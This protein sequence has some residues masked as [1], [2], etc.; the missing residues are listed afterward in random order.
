MPS[1]RQARQTLEAAMRQVLFDEQMVPEECVSDENGILYGFLPSHVP[2]AII[3]KRYDITLPV[4]EY[5]LFYWEVDDKGHYVAGSARISPNIWRASVI[6]RSGR[7]LDNEVILQSLRPL[8]WED[9]CAH[10]DLQFLKDPEGDLFAIAR[11]FWQGSDPA[12]SFGEVC[13]VPTSFN[14]LKDSQQ[15]AQLRHSFLRM[16]KGKAS[17]EG[18]RT[19]AYG[20]AAATPVDKATLKAPKNAPLAAFIGQSLVDEKSLF[21]PLLAPKDD[22][23][24][25]ERLILFP[26]DD[27]YFLQGALANMVFLQAT[28]LANYENEIDF[29][30]KAF[31]N[32]VLKD[33]HLTYF[34][35]YSDEKALALDLCRTQDILKDLSFKDPLRQVITNGL[36]FDKEAGQLMVEDAWALMTYNGDAPEKNEA[37]LRKVLAKTAR[38]D[39]ADA[40]GRFIAAVEKAQAARAALQKGYE[41]ALARDEAIL[42]FEK[43]QHDLEQ[44][45]AQAEKGLIQAVEGDNHLHAQKALAK[46]NLEQKTNEKEAAKNAWVK[47]KTLRYEQGQALNRLEEE[48]EKARP[49]LMDRL[50]NRADDGKV[51]AL[52]DEIKSIEQQLPD[53]VANETALSVAYELAERALKEAETEL[54]LRQRDLERAESGKVAMQHGLALAEEALKVL[55]KEKKETIGDLTAALRQHPDIFQKPVAE[56]SVFLTD[57]Y[58]DMAQQVFLEALNLR[59]AALAALP[60]SFLEAAKDPSA[61]AYQQARKLLYPLFVGAVPDEEMTFALALV[62]EADTDIMLFSEHT[63]I[64][65]KGGKGDVF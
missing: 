48:L 46:K 60:I 31:L 37:A 28:H 24:V 3:S 20:L 12:P 27:R 62:K 45:L 1:K 33:Q 16:E 26:Y 44:E 40:R 14:Y 5:A 63:L 58:S 4:G 10:L 55:P 53:L 39:Y 25:A 41:L 38:S 21:L 59:R 13:Y 23:D 56:T 52:E 43:R 7:S 49:S 8:A 47:A 6:A 19:L 65:E 54:T 18:M 32:G 22:I 2:E 61:L 50:L 11:A 30:Q 42:Y 51:A 35:L 9:A 34:L 36:Y 57:A 64:L 17:K 29:A 15:Y